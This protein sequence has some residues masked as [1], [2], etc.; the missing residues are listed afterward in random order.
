[1]C[2]RT[3]RGRYVCLLGFCPVERTKEGS[4]TRTDATLVHAKPDRHAGESDLLILDV[5]W[6]VFSLL[7]SIRMLCTLYT[8]TLAGPEVEEL[9]H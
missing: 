1:M 6:T 7:Y 2:V 9:P 4:Q 3:Y 5:H 8:Y